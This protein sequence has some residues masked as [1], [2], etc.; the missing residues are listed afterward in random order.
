MPEWLKGADCKSAVAR[1]R[2]FESTPAHHYKELKSSFFI[3]RA[4]TQL[5]AEHYLR[6]ERAC[7]WKDFLCSKRKVCEKRS[8]IVLNESEQD[9]PSLLEL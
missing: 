3:G 8:E 9:T 1:L 2:W 4:N 6:F 5:G 7:I